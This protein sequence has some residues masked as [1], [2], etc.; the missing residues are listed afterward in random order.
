ML[1]VIAQHHDLTGRAG[2]LGVDQKYL[3]AQGIK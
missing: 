3:R 2:F 1:K